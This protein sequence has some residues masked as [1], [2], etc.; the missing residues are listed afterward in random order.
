MLLQLIRYGHDLPARA[1]LSE[2]ST[3]VELLPVAGAVFARTVRH[4]RNVRILTSEAVAIRHRSG[5]A[6]IVAALFTLSRHV[7]VTAR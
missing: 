2:D 1:M 5:V 4:F 6:V 7:H 3:M